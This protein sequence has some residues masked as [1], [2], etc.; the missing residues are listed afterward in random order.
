MVAL[1]MLRD[2]RS[3]AMA[4]GEG[5][6]VQVGSRPQIVEV[7]ER[8]WKSGLDIEES[9]RLLRMLVGWWMGVV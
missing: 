5:E 7:H 6:R 9:V 2:L 8:P 3:S 4:G 1:G